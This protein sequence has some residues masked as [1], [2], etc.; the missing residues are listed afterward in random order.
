PTARAAL[1]QQICTYEH[2]FFP[3]ND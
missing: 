2:D 1:W 3:R